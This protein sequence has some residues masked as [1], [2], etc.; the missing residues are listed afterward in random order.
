VQEYDMDEWKQHTV[1]EDYAAHDDV[2][3]WFWQV[4]SCATHN[5]PTDNMLFRE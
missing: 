1:Y 4:T 2:I 5:N 3:L